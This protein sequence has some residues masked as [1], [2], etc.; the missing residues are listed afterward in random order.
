MAMLLKH[1]IDNGVK[2]WN[3]QHQ[4]TNFYGLT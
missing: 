2:L 3:K 4:K 1:L